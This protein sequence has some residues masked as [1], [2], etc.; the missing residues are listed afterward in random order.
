VPVAAERGRSPHG[1]LQ[2]LAFLGDPTGFGTL[3]NRDDRALEGGAD[4]SVVP[5]RPLHLVA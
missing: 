1:F 5:R 2:L 3:G 4:A